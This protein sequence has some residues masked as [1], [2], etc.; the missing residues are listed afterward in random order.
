M[1]KSIK[2][3]TRKSIVSLP[4]VVLLMALLASTGA[5]AQESASETDP[6]QFGLSI[7]GWFPNIAG[8]TVFSQSDG[9]G[10]FEVDIDNILGN[11]DDELELGGRGSRCVHGARGG[12]GI[13]ARH[14]HAL[15]G[16]AAPT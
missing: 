16:L 7:Y 10:D 8:Q 5:F 14:R 15:A 4:L 13:D 6:W 12:I 2:S 3:T 1:R 11:A 9:G